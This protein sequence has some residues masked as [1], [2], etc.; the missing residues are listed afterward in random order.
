[1]EKQ[2]LTTGNDKPPSYAAATAPISEQQNWNF[3]VLYYFV[4]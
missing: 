4:V 1:M 3:T 2:P